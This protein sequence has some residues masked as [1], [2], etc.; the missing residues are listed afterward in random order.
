MAKEQRKA[1]H[2]SKVEEFSDKVQGESSVGVD[3]IVG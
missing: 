3:A 2:G 1:I